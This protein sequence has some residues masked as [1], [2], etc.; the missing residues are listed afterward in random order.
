MPTTNVKL[1]TEES[2]LVT[3]S[4][5]ILTKS[6]IIH[7]VVD[8]FGLI[9]KEYE[10]LIKNELLFLPVEV[11]KKNSKISKGEQYKK[12]PF[13]MLDYPRYFSQHNTFAIRSFFWWGNFFSITLHLSG[14]F[15]TQYAEVIFN[16]LKEKNFDS[17]FVCVNENEWEHHFEEDNYLPASLYLSQPSSF[18]ALKQKS[19]LKL[20]KKI[21]LK[22]W[23][24]GFQFFT[25]EYK[26]ILQILNH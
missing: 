19:F 23:D 5:I 16:K 3:N 8:L 13:V 24:H 11:L 4:D 14:N 17:W 6:R 15:A 26:D 9:Y 25:K 22:E 20:A 21:P 1:S 12:L 7:K 10:G 2:A 18:D